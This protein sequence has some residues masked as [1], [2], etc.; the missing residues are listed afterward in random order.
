LSSQIYT[1]DLS[2][3]PP[4]PTVKKNTPESTSDSTADT[5]GAHLE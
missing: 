4:Y 3:M 5:A 1:S 2:G